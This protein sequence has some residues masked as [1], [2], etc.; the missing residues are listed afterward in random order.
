MVPL[1]LAAAVC[2]S[3][4]GWTQETSVRLA[5]P[6]APS[7]EAPPAD[8]GT[9]SYA[10]IED[11]GSPYRT[12]IGSAAL[13]NNNPTG[14]GNTAA[15]HYALY[16]NTSGGLN[17]GVGAWSLYS[18]TT[19]N[20]NTA[21]GYTSLWSNTTGSYNTALGNMSLYQNTTGQANTAVGSESL[22]TAT[23]GQANTGVGVN[24]L[25]S[26]SG[27]NNTAL[28][29]H[30]GQYATSGTYNLFLGAYARGA[31][32]D[33]NTIRIGVP[34]DG[35]AG[36]NKTFIAGIRGIP[37]TNAMPV[38]IDANGQLGT[39]GGSDGSWMSVRG[40]GENYGL[41]FSSASG[42]KEIQSYENEPLHINRQGNNTILNALYGSVGIGTSVPGGAFKLRVGGNAAVG[43]SDGSWMS[44][45]GT[46]ENYGLLLSSVSGYK[47]IQSYEAEPLYINRQGN[48]TI[49]NADSGNVGIGTG[50]PVHPL[51]MRSGAHVTAGG[52]WTNA[53]SRTLKQ[54]IAD[55]PLEDAVQAIEQLAPVTY[56][57]K[58][59]PG[60]RHVGFIAE[61]V[62]ALVATG[63]RKSLSPMDIVA[64]LTRVV[65][66]Q[67]ASQDALKATVAELQA[68]TTELQ[69]QLA[70]ARQR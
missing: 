35:A 2:G 67:Q 53:S 39:A 12:A 30:A 23:S 7:S 25:R 46:G 60:E 15:G 65:Q 22:I 44:V 43:G 3:G 52:V 20:Y 51:Q 24:A 13:A 5:P 31:A 61:D 16:S 33:T 26:T 45:L 6:A 19:G 1:I 48:N 63:D 68:K 50:S 18:S 32:A 8:P 49:L 40:T 41:V 59:S 38:V 14:L 47:E 28:G 64:V 42:Y 29:A 56:R 54:D 55:L 66:A 62:P 21:S 11:P 37:V 57:Y 34:Y 69:R 36:Q 27:S 17:T 58:A 4:M 70:A 10:I 9:G